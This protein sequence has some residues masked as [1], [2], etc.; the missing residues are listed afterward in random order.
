MSARIA[1]V[2]PTFPGIIDPPMTNNVKHWDAILA[3]RAAS[4]QPG[5]TLQ[6]KIAIAASPGVEMPQ[7][8]PNVARALPGQ[9]ED[10]LARF[11]AVVDA[12]FTLATR[13]GF[14]LSIPFSKLQVLDT[15]YMGAPVPSYMVKLAVAGKPEELLVYKRV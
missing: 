8:T 2:G 15:F 10:T 5:L 13:R 14:D 7:G 1:S 6:Q 9:A 3:L 12:L 4:T 11:N